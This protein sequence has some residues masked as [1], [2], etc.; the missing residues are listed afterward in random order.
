MKKL[1]YIVTVL[2]IAV[3]LYSCTDL[4]ETVRDTALQQDA[5]EHADASERTLAPVYQL[6]TDPLMRHN[7]LNNLQGVASIE[8]I[9][10]FRG[11]TD[12]FDGG[13]FIEMHQHT[14]TPVH[15]TIIDVWQN[16]TQAIGRGA[17]AQKTI[18][19]NGGDPALAAEA[20][21]LKA[22]YNW[23]LLDLYNVAFDKQPEDVGTPTLST[24]YRG[25]EAVDYIYNELDE[26][27]SQLTRRASDDE[28]RFNQDA[29]KALKVRLL[30]NKAVYSDRYASEFSHNT[31]DLN[32]VID[33]AT[34]LINDGYFQLEGD[35]YFDLFGLENEG[36]PEV[37][38]SL[39]QH[40]ET[41]G[42]RRMGYFHSSRDR[43]G[44]LENPSKTGSDGGALTQNFYDLWEGERDDPRY[45]RQNMPNGGT[46]S[47]E[48]FEWNRGV[49]I[50][51]QYGIVRDFEGAG[52]WK[53]D[54]NGDLIVEALVDNARSGDMMN[55]SREVGIASDR[56]HMAGPRSLKW[57]IDHVNPEGSAVNFPVLRLGEMYLSRAEAYA[58]LDDWGAA[59]DDINDLRGQ[60]GA[61]LLDQSE[62]QTMQD[63][64]REW[65]FEMW[66]EHLTRTIQIRF[67][68]FNGGDFHDVGWRDKEVSDVIRRVYPI[69][70]NA[71]DA[72]Q[73]EPGYLEQNQGY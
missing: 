64:E 44:H 58:R 1:I 62:L 47:D 34:E 24:V 26:V 3:V 73:G 13:R 5:L 49:E 72:A 36:H 52:L 21:A 41:G 9:V 43:Y 12:W 70:Q 40:P 18:N 57:S 71:I 6:M 69:P 28:T 29:V 50:G 48:E 55:Y 7:W 4:T 68:S 56:G 67:N 51:Q 33:Y 61:R 37:I 23:W 19:E 31:E 54:E 53:R 16:F 27:Q 17:I 22:L 35:N 66:M 65:I 39:D 32:D 20:R 14:W 45:H 38:F 2:F 63:L 59:L 25:A 60:R 8:Q 15:I 30:L 10:P 42:V 11:G 46:I